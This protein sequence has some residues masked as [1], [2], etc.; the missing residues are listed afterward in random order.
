M[1]TKYPRSC[2]FSWSESNTSDDVWWTDKDVEDNFVGREVVVSL[3]IDGE[4]TNLYRDHYHARSL[5]SPHH[6][7]RNWIK[8]FHATFAYEMDENIRFCGEN[9]YAFHSLFYTDLPTYFFLFGVY[10]QERCFSWD[11]TEEY[12]K[13][14][15]L[16]TVPVL[17]RGIWNE[18][19][20]RENWTGEGPF[21]AYE[22]T[23]DPIRRQ[24][25]EDFTP[26]NHEGYVVRLA[27]SF[28]FEDFRESL[29]KMV[30][31][32]HVKTAQNWMQLSVVP[33]QLKV[34]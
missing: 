12:A 2:H 33:N 32:N 14:F 27:D 26:S 8:K 30:R 6:P 24:F 16:I 31:K 9:C 1:K 11:E 18:K 22:C 23:G 5:D 34:L 17:Y 25:P 20:I 3:K 7:S 28:K 10:D 15:G 19:L 4:C 13:L 29:C 21:P